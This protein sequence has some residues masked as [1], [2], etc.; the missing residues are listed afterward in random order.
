MASDTSVKYSVISPSRANTYKSTYRRDKFAYGLNR[1]KS[2]K[3]VLVS[4]L[5]IVVAMLL[6]LF[7]TMIVYSDGSLFY[8]VIEQI[9]TAPFKGS[10]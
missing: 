8:K 4:I 1:R 2:S 6:A 3:S 10:N 9:F 7:I 5:S